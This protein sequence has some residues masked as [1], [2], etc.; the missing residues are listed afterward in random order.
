MSGVTDQGQPDGTLAV[1]TDWDPSYMY[2]AGEVISTID[3]LEKW[4]T[5]SSRAKECSP[6]AMQ[7][8]R[9]ESILTSPPPPNTETAGYGIGIGNRNGWLV[10]HTARSRAT[11]PRSSTT[12]TRR[13]P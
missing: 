12:T 8:V 9:R 7:D 4:R 1:A 2:A 5:R 11:T 6:P 3:D 10:G 13:R